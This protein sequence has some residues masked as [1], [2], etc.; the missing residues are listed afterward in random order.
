LA[1]K[2]ERDTPITI[3]E[4]ADLIIEHPATEKQAMPENYG[5]ISGTMILIV[6]LCA[7]DI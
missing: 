3:L 5:L 4:S 2:I 7:I 6:E 1:T